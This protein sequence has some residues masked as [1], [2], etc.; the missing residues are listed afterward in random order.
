MASWEAETMTETQ[1][2]QPI[3]ELS[4]KYCTQHLGIEIAYFPY[5]LSNQKLDEPSG[6]RNRENPLARNRRSV[7]TWSGAWR[8]CVTALCIWGWVV[9]HVWVTWVANIPLLWRA[10]V[11]FVIWAN[12]IT[13]PCL[14]FSLQIKQE[15][16]SPSEELGGLIKT[17]S[18]LRLMPIVQG[19]VKILSGAQFTHPSRRWMTANCG[20]CRGELLGEATEKITD[21]RMVF[22]GEE[23]RKAVLVCLS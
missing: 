21:G 15:L 18:G 9:L 12:H 5:L 6:C 14:R 7:C 13:S 20:R 16:S 23:A 2:E 4:K 8:Y 1:L 11:T 3:S 17:Y 10:H 22:L 19:I